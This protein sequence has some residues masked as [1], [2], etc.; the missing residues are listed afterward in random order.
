MSEVFAQKLRLPR[1]RHDLVEDALKVISDPKVQEKIIDPK[2]MFGFISLWDAEL[3]ELRQWLETAIGPA[4][5]CLSFFNQDMFAHKDPR[6]RS[7]IIYILEPGG[8]NVR[9]NFYEDDKE[10]R[11]SSEL[12]LAHEWSLLNASR[13]HD[14]VGIEPGQ[15]RYAITA[16]MHSHTWGMKPGEQFKSQEYSSPIYLPVPDRNKLVHLLNSATRHEKAERALVEPR[17]RISLAEMGEYPM[18]EIL[19][20]TVHPGKWAVEIINSSGVTHPDPNVSAELSLTISSPTGVRTKYW[21][22][23]SDDHHGNT[24]TT[25]LN[26]WFLN[27][28][29]SYRQIQFCQP[30]DYTGPQINLVCPLL[31][32]DI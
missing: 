14:V 24:Y 28:A 15:Y 20:K 30:E 8:K 16:R 25:Q 5:W 10:T 19:S 18:L 22:S 13:F 2:R 17:V 4:L 26:R 12:L 21:E 1:I 7:R 31:G 11:L 3:T 29:S 32:P 6:S 23:M 27:V 9:T